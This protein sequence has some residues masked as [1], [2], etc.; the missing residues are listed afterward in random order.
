M[1][2]YRSYHRHGA[3]L[4]GPERELCEEEATV[5]K[6]T[7]MAMFRSKLQ[8]LEWIKNEPNVER[9]HHRLVGWANQ[10]LASQNLETQVLN[11]P[12]MCSN[13]LQLITSDM[14]SINA[15]AL[16]PFIRGVK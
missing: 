9:V 8:N 16:W 6:D 13:H 5:A 14:S 15:P 3:E 12:R 2:K 10:Y 4:D 1:N 11:S 7:L